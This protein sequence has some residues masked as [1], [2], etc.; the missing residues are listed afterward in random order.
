MSLQFSI[1]MERPGFSLQLAGEFSAGCT[2][3]FGSSGAGKSTLFNALAGQIKPQE[4]RITLGEHVLFDSMSGVYLPP[5]KR[6]VGVVFQDGRLFPHLSVKRNLLYACGWLWRTRPTLPMVEVTDILG[7]T[8]LLHKKPGQLSGGEQQRVAIGRALLAGPKILLLDEPFSALDR[9]RKEE[10]IA[11]LRRIEERFSIP[12]VLVSHDL[13]DIL[14]LTR[15]IYCI[16]NGRCTGYGDFTT[17]AIDD[18][19]G[20]TVTNTNIHPAIISYEGGGARVLRT[21]QGGQI[22][23]TTG[24]QRYK[25]AEEVYLSIHPEE[26][27]VSLAP[28]E[29]ISIQNQLQARVL[30]LQMRGESC[31][32]HASAGGLRLTADLT[33]KAAREFSLQE[34]GNIWLLF[35]ARAVETW[36]GLHSASAVPCGS[37]LICPR[38]TPILPAFSPAN[39]K[40]ATIV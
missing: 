39:K 8:H 40:T 9:S 32:L 16:E 21:L 19:M 10:I 22:I 12:L 34:G 35:K 18:N 13:R 1:R 6:Q 25:A 38:P 14:Q 30:S 20:G 33:R 28:V 29:Y 3:V 37:L 27:A 5:Q 7:I 36:A 2:G 31:L 4:G 17:F 15:K 11:Y 23:R 24:L 26:I